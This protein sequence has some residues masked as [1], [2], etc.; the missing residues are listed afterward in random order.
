M[1]INWK[2]KASFSRVFP[3]NF[4]VTWNSTSSDLAPV[5]TPSVVVIGAKPSNWIG[6]A[7]S[8]VVTVTLFNTRLVIGSTGFVKRV[9]YNK[10]KPLFGKVP[11]PLG[12][13]VKWFL[14]IT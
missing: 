4:L 3:S 8:L 2:L 12:V 13:T 5:P 6:L 9:L 1:S 14:S 10:Y 7:S 11:S